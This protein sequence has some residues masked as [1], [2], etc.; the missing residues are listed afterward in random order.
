[1]NEPF[2][3]GLPFGQRHDPDRRD[4]SARKIAL[5]GEAHKALFCSTLLDTH[6]PYRPRVLD[7]PR[8]DP[9]T[10]ARITSLPIWD[11]AVR[12]EGRAGMNVRTFAETVV[13]PHLRAALDMDAF[14]E[15]RHRTVLANMV[16]AYGVTLEPEPEYRRPRDPEWAFMVTGYAECID[17]FF[18]FGLFDIARRSGFFPPELVDTFEPVMREEARHILFFVNWVAWR[19]RNLPLWR[20]PWFELRVL[21]VWL[22]L[23]RERL[24]L[25]RDMEKNPKGQDHN[26]TLSGSKE[27]GVQISFAEL[28]KACLA[29]NDRRLAA[30][31]A[32]LIRPK[33]VPGMVRLALRLAGA[34]RPRRA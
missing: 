19:R 17:S 12:T 2:Y 32:A 29:E 34:D 4:A 11:V 3:A 13:D 20:R 14:E 10:Q 7:W 15:G 31:P 30:Y 16:E 1:M 24:G 26:F 25:A 18:G 28:A 27:L 6:D 5:G 8:L 9:E 33:F 21:A 23:I 22:F